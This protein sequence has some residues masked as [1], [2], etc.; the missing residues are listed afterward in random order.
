MNNPET[1]PNRKNSKIVWILITLI[2]IASNIILLVS[3][4]HAKGSSTSGGTA[5]GSST[6]SD[7]T[8]GDNPDEIISDLQIDLADCRVRLDDAL[9]REKDY[10]RQIDSQKRNIQKLQTD[11]M[12]LSTLSAG[13]MQDFRK[14]GLANPERDIIADLMA[15]PELIPVKPTE[16][17]TMGF[18]NK[19]QIFVLNRYIVYAQFTDGKKIGTML[20]EYE[21]EDGGK[22]KWKPLK[23]YE[24]L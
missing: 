22:I 3:F 18:Y 17:A 8:A 12:G 13:A 20:L 4:I 11:V 6:L 19:K 24:S 15:H 16:G 14:K 7:R 5:A 21:V 2:L 9:A 23:A 1:V 10:E